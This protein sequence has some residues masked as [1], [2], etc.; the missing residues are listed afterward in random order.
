MMDKNFVEENQDT[1][2]TNKTF[3]YPSDIQFSTSALLE[4]LESYCADLEAY[5]YSHQQAFLARATNRT[6]SGQLD[7]VEKMGIELEE[8]WSPFLQKL[9]TIPE[10]DLK[11]YIGEDPRLASYS[12]FMERIRKQSPS[13]R[14]NHVW[15]LLTQLK[16]Q[17]GSAK[18]Q[19]NALVNTDFEFGSIELDG[20]RVPVRRT[21]V[22]RL[23]VDK[24][25]DTRKKA[26]GQYYKQ[27]D[28]HKHTLAAIFRTHIAQEVMFTRIQGAP[29]TRKRIL[30]Q[31]G[32][33]ESVHE[34]LLETIGGRVAS[35]HRYFA[36]RKSL[37]GVKRLEA[38]DLMVPL[39]EDIPFYHSYAQAVE[40]I[41]GSV[42]M[43]GTRF[44]SVLEDGLL[45][46]WSDYGERPGK[47]PGAF[48][49]T[50]YRGGPSVHLN[51]KEEVPQSLFTLAHESG[52]AMHAWYSIHHNPFHNYAYDILVAET[53]A[54]VHE[55]LLSKYLLSNAHSVP[56]KA[57]LLERQLQGMTLKLLRQTLL[58]DFEHKVFLSEERG[59]PMT[60][61]CMRDLFRS[62]WEHYYGPDVHL[63]IRGDLEWLTVDQLYSPYYA[64]T[65]PTG[66]SAALS[67][68]ESIS[69][70]DENAISRYKDLL[71]S[72]G[73]LTPGETLS[74]VGIDITG[75]T[76]YSQAMERYE[77]TLQTFG[78]M[79]ESLELL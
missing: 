30:D 1:K 45:K 54:S 57:F 51:Y 11:C 78:E 66:A 4:S 53:V 40:E 32:I 24:D 55:E 68:A 77:A 46:S 64:Y 79:V 38:Y 71:G 76:L 42:A 36:L 22:S 17:S 52:H 15:Q 74:L 56:A 69:H 47:R 62:L 39:I 8:R 3:H 28:A 37:M 73:S 20:I 13:I 35:F 2:T 6:D 50:S 63:G 18:R 65:Y 41:C 14:G 9:A 25:R 12:R 34:T 5:E 72:G 43:F 67:I 61:Q 7:S 60:L 49:S 21:T 75:E 44:V 16:A 48:T 70:D 23:L 19:F 59:E 27:F 58:A 29:S 26:Y 33:S 31:D 10:E